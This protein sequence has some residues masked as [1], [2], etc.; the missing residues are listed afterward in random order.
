MTIIRKTSIVQLLFSIF[1]FSCQQ[2]KKDE[3]IALEDDLKKPEDIIKLYK[4]LKKNEPDEHNFYDESELNH[5]GYE[6]P[7]AGKTD[8]EINIQSLC[9]RISRFW[10][11]V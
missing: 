4:R 5:L 2:Q 6:L 7:G 3:D 1:F 11:S 9:F 8:S 10:K